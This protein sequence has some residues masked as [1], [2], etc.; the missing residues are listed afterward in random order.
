[1]AI[2]AGWV[3]HGSGMVDIRLVLVKVGVGQIVG[4]VEKN[5]HDT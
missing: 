4:Y 5:E 2:V 3:G 1:M